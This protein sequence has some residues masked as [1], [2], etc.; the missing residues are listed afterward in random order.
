LYNV[1]VGKY[2]GEEFSLEQDLNTDIPVPSLFRRE[3]KETWW[4]NVGTEL[5]FQVD[6]TN[7]RFKDGAYLRLKYGQNPENMTQFS[8]WTMDN[9]VYDEKTNSFNINLNLAK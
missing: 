1:D 4:G 8:K 3:Y 7:F 6:D 5:K 2:F 9:Y